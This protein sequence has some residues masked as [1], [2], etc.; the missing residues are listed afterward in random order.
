MSNLN[1]F[2][3]EKTGKEQSVEELTKQ[4]EHLEY[5]LEECRK[6]R[7]HYQQLFHS[8]PAGYLVFDQ[9]RRIADADQRFCSMV[10]VP[11]QDRCSYSIRDLT[12]KDTREE[13][14]MMIHGLLKKDQVLSIE[15]GCCAGIVISRLS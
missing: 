2:H 9:E 4:I 7:M 15:P 12:D 6:K 1:H 13:L 3:L 14:D 10:Y 8:A 5:N 11:F